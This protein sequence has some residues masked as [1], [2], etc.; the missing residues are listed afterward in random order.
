M[1]KTY[2]VNVATRM[3][4]SLLMMLLRA[5]VPGHR[6]GRGGDHRLVRHP[7]HR[8]LPQG[9]VRF[10]RGCHP[11]AQPGHRLRVRPGYRPVPAVS[12]EPVRG[13]RPPQTRAS[14]L[15]EI[16]TFLQRN[17]SQAMQTD[18]CD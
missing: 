18:T 15:E 3:R 17:S 14:H 16:V 7:V 10:R 6:G 11:L 8:A 12:A 13:G 2:H 1:A 4:D 9:D 5:G